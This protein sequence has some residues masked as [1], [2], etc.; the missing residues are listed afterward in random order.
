MG[1]AGRVL[2][3][4]CLEQ[5][6]GDLP[7]SSGRCRIESP[8]TMMATEEWPC[9]ESLHQA[10]LQSC[11]S[12]RRKRMMNASHWNPCRC[13]FCADPSQEHQSVWRSLCCF[14]L[15]QIA[16]SL[17]FCLLDMIIESAAGVA[18]FLFYMISLGRLERQVRAGWKGEQLFG[19]IF[20]AIPDATGIV[21]RFAF[22][23]SLFPL[24]LRRARPRY[25]TSSK[26]GHFRFVFEARSF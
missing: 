11:P 25:I 4:C 7:E 17:C 8:G 10:V 2:R 3:P 14:V 19:K 12:N 6:R 26:L 15:F 23:F 16:C 1:S 18:L 22:Y 24:K 5:A 9:L 20:C 21:A 13:I